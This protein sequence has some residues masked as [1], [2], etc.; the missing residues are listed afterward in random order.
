MFSKIIK[1]DSM[2]I[3]FPRFG[4]GNFSHFAH[5]I[6]NFALPFYSMLKKN[7]LLGLLHESHHLTI[8]LLD[9]TKLHFGPLLPLAH[10]IFIKIFNPSDVLLPK[11]QMAQ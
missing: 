2:A 7:N 6:C 1:M 5:F 11:K 8:E 9:K 4:R 10:E 3:S